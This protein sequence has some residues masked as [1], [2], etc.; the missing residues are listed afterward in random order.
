MA[1]DK[2]KTNEELDNLEAEVVEESKSEQFVEDNIK[3][4]SMFV[5][6]GIA[7]I[8]AAAWFLMSSADAE[9]ED[10]K[11]IYKAQY[12]YS[13]DSLDLALFGDDSA[14]VNED[15]IGFD[16]LTK[17]L[18]SSKVKN[19]NF[20]YV[21]SIN[22]QNGEYQQAV[23]YLSDFSSDNDLL[24][25]RAKCLLGDAYMELA[26]AD[27]NYSSAIE[28]YTEATE[29]AS[30]KSFTPGYMLKL[31]L[32]QELSG[33]ADAAIAT[34]EKLIN[35]FPNGLQEVTEAKKYKTVLEVKKGS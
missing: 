4:I 30:N 27:Q 6:G 2:N 28:S 16:A 20:F 15:L 24:L 13:L 5:A 25:S 26:E 11:M 19:L 35:N 18:Q 17:E 22:L 34:Y 9:V 14:L 23:D 31:A 12:Y 10:Q 32:A 33:A 8:V 7:I 29:L 3:K 1:E 21:G